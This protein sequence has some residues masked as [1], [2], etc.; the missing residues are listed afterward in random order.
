MIVTTDASDIG[1]GAVLEQEF[2]TNGIKSFQPLEFYSR[3]HTNAQKI[4]HQM[5]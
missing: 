2:E 4:I 3:S 5:K 1:Y